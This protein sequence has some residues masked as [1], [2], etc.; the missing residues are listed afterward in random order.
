MSEALVPA[1]AEHNN[2]HSP[3]IQ[4]PT[5]PLP[6]PLT[7]A[8]REHATQK[9]LEFADERWALKEGPQFCI[10][11]DTAFWPVLVLN[12]VLDQF[13]LLRSRESL[14]THLSDWDFLSSDSDSLFLLLEQLN[15]RYDGRILKS[16]ELKAWK[17]AA[18]RAR[19]KARK[20]VESAAMKE[21]I[22]PALITAETSRIAKTTPQP[23]RSMEF[24]PLMTSPPIHYPPATPSALLPMYYPYMMPQPI[25]YSAPYYFPHPGPS[26]AAEYA[27]QPLAESSLKRSNVIP[28]DQ[29][30]SNAER[31]RQF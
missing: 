7:K 26:V 6:P 28:A 12:C 14:D 31:S 11:P 23:L 30:G 10:I 21:N 19:N 18:T 8:C 17:A 9:L 22:P 16:K 29:Q 24:T 20:Q 1:K 13:H 3:G 5:V 27:T 25:P 4:I 2:T 15:K